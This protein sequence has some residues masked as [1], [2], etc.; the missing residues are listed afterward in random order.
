[1]CF[2]LT[3]VACVLLAVI[4]SALMLSAWVAV[5]VLQEARKAL[6]RMIGWGESRTGGALASSTPDTIPA[7]VTDPLGVPGSAL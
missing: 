6:L 1:M 2:V 7:P 4:A 3:Y 5:L